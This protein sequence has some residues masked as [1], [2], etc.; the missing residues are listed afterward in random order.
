LSR[1]TL[2]HSI[3]ARTTLARTILAATG[4]GVLVAGAALAGSSSSQA[5][6]DSATADAFSTSGVF[7]TSRPIPAALAVPAGN[8]LTAAFA[9]QGVQVYQCTAGAWTFVEPAASLIGQATKSHRIQTAVHFRG[10]SWESTNDGSLVTAT[11]VANSPVAGS[12]PELLLKS[13]TNRGTGL[14]G[15]VS[16]IQRLSTTGGAAP[17]GS[18]TDGQTTGVTYTAKYRFYSPS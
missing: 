15:K 16:Y 18:C 14:F 12:I 13:A 10:P 9:A 7:A 3:L 5:A 11:A 1:T 17:A 4:V 8:S 6:V 2:A